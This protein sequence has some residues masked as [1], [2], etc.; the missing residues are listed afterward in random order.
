MRSADSLFAKGYA[1]SQFVKMVP[2]KMSLVLITRFN[3]ELRTVHSAGN[4]KNSI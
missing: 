2:V 1:L 3:K 4:L